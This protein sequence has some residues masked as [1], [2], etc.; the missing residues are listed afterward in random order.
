MTAKDVAELMG[1][2]RQSFSDYERGRNSPSL[3][4][5]GRF[6][7]VLNVPVQ[8]FFQFTNEETD[9][10]EQI[11]KF[12]KIVED[13]KPPVGSALRKMTQREFSKIFS[14]ERERSKKKKSA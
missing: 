14:V 4:L 13:T 1:I 7:V 11:R 10:T 3:D 9:F 12:R 8:I 2:T 5:V 6:S